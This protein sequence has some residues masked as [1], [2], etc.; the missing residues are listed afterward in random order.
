MDDVSG[1]WGQLYY[2]WDGNTVTWYSPNNEY[3]QQNLNG[4]TYYYF[5]IL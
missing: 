2:T 5:A 4:M 1:D 3:S